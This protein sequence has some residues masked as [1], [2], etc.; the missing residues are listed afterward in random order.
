MVN[1]IIPY[2]IWEWEKKE[3]SGLKHVV[4]FSEDIFILFIRYPYICS[5]EII[6]IFVFYL[7]WI[8]F[9]IYIRQTIVVLYTCL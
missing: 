4:A 8:A 5:L 2:L 1:L 9:R 6:K 7:N 3:L